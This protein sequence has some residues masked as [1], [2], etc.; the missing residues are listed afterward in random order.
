MNLTVLSIGYPFA[1]TGPDAVGGVEQILSQL[2]FAMAQAGHR[3]IVIA[4]EG[5]VT[6]GRL[7]PVPR[8]NGTV[9]AER[10]GV[11][12]SR[13]REA[14]S[15]VLESTRVDL[16]HMHGIDFH[17]YLPPPGPPLLVTLHLPPAWYPPE[18]FRPS[19]PSTFLHCV[20]TAQR[21][22]CPSSDAL[23]P[24]IENG[25]P[26]HVLGERCHAKRSFAVAL[27]RICPEKGFHLALDAAISA[28]VPLL[29]AGEV[30][31][32]ETH[33]HYFNAEITPRLGPS[34]RFVGR[35]GLR[36][37]RRLLSAA[38]CLLVPSLVAET[39]SLVAMEAMA[40]GTP[41]VAFPAGALADIIEPGKTGWLVS[42]VDEMA[43]AILA[44]RA[45]STE[46]CRES[47]RWRF[48]SERM[49]ADY[50]ALYRR[51]AGA[52]ASTIGQSRPVE[53]YE[54]AI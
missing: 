43:Q 17:E 9:T 49:V 53:E 27:G 10:R 1:P 4:P 8:T 42:D 30:F 19:R 41:V 21:K 14:I 15:D 2:D 22:S 38:R 7:I 5:S 48:A 46:V 23:L 36:R 37:K 18:V 33:Q 3:S 25:V 16:V 47:A 29:L 44:C 34:R 35:V 6:A 51:L 32:Y 13:V 11:V 24:E 28:N 26:V 20:S 12:Y 39:S 31:G 40:C 54:C 45:L 52:E 50:F